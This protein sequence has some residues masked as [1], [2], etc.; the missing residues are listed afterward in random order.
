[1]RDTILFGGVAAT[2]ASAW[3]S[4]LHLFVFYSD[5][6]HHYILQA[7]IRCAIISR[8]PSNFRDFY[9]MVP[10]NYDQVIAIPLLWIRSAPHSYAAAVKLSA[11]LPHNEHRNVQYL[12]L[13]ELW[14]PA[15]NPGDPAGELWP[16]D[17]DRDKDS[18]QGL[19]QKPPGIWRRLFGCSPH[20]GRKHEGV[21]GT[22]NEVEEG[23]MVH[24]IHK[25]PCTKH[26]ELCLRLT[27]L[28][29]PTPLACN[30]PHPPWTTYW[31]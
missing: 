14:Y 8:P 30:S 11:L 1:M 31:S 22:V 10:H 27:S 13:L 29:T 25:I 26:G 19:L 24:T 2:P 15:C 9:S 16:Y 23:Q 7:H 28:P 3:A 12:G 20:R 21:C 17:C 18:R 5:P 4:S 6:D